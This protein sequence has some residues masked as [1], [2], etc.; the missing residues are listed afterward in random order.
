M[1]RV[2]A[3]A[4]GLVAV[5]YGCGAGGGSGRLEVWAHAGRTE[6]RAVI[7]EQ[8]RAFD[9]VRDDLAVRVTFLP[10]GSYSGQ[11][12][13]ATAAGTLPDVLELDGPTVA[14]AAWQG[15]LR[16][17]DDLL[18]PSLVAEL[19]PSLREQGRY[20]GRLWSVS[21]RARRRLATVGVYA[22]LIAVTAVFVAPVVVVFVALQRWFVR[23]VATTG[24]KG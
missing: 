7:A 21:P 2:T 14:R 15:A 13:A 1:E 20:D 24:V 8:I 22:A 12:Q 11:V 19:L 6:E 4:F 16:P 10:E 9:E 3:V 17:L 23:G 18:P 5:A